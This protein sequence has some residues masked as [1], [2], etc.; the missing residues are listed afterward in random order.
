MPM[1][2]ALTSTRAG[3]WHI[4]SEGIYLVGFSGPHA[5]ELAVQR[6]QEL[7][8]LLDDV[9]AARPPRGDARTAAVPDD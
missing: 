6:H 2:L 5:H 4:T 7:A 9:D 3:E 8:Q 1:R